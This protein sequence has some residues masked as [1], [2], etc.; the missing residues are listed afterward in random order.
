V[1][2]GRYILFA[3]GEGYKILK[4]IEIRS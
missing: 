4:E 3:S 2:K 1:S